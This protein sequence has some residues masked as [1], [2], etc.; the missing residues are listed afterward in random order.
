MLLYYLQCEILLPQ[1][2]YNIM[3]V[4]ELVVNVTSSEL[5]SLQ[6]LRSHGM[7]SEETMLP[8]REKE[9]KECGG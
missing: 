4:N 3:I 7:L 6:Y 5:Q 1:D 2:S 9:E 8:T